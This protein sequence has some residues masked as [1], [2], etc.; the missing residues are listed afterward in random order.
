MK[1]KSI[2]VKTSP[3]VVK[4][5]IETSGL[6]ISSIAK[7]LRV[8]E[9]TVLGWTKERHKV[10]IVKLERLAEYVKRPLAVFLLDSPPKERVLPDCRRQSSKITQKT[11]L[12]IRFARYLQEAA[13]EIMGSLGKETS[14]DVRSDITVQQ[15]AEKVAVEER[16]R[17]G[18]DECQIVAKPRDR[19]RQLYDK[20]R[21]A[22]E[23]RN[24]LVFEQSADREEMSG[25]SMSGHPCVILINSKDTAETK[26]FTLMHEYGH[27]L[28]GREGLCVPNMHD[29]DPSS[30]KRMAEAW[31]NQFAAFVLMPRERF[32]E[33]YRKL[34][35][36]GTDHTE[37]IER[38]A[39]EFGTSKL[40]T[41]THAGNLKLDMHG[42]VNKIGELRSGQARQVSAA[43][44]RVRE[45]GRKFVSLVLSARQAGVI[46][47]R[48]AVDYLDIDLNYTSE[49]QK[50]L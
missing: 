35:E 38:L 18:L 8:S 44:K 37:M 31:C 49:L 50:M 41:Y 4:W 36:D 28:L 42:F 47:G 45:R 16:K 22:V 20:L 43:S 14:P 10:S 32:L 7:R 13:R 1:T 21:E 24:I 25:L 2:K 27:I 9:D 48:D 3:D 46:T 12:S 23:S 33:E 15:S 11:A 26:R 19:A 5:V 6:E 29:W 17:L 30:D 40:V 39:H 34:E